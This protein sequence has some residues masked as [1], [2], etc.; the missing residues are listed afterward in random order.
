MSLGILYADLEE[1]LDAVHARWPL[2]RAILFGSRA[3]GDELVASDYDLILVSEAFSGMGFGE[4]IERIFELWHLPEPLQP[5]CY[6][7]EEFERKKSEIGVVRVAS[8]EGLCLWRD[9]HAQR[10]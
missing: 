5:L 9:G 8:R 3:R 6:T 7:P 2:E 10:G 1:F 4:R